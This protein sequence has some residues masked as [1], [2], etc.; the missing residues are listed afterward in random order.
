MKLDA[1]RHYWR[2]QAEAYPWISDELAVFKR[3]FLP[4][5]AFELDKALLLDGVVAVQA[6]ASECE[7]D[8]LLA[9]AQQSA[10]CH[11]KEQIAPILGIVGWVDL[12]AATVDARLDAYRDQP[13]MRGFRHLVQDE[14]NPSAFWARTDFNRG[15]S[16]LQKR[17]FVYDVLVKQAD[18]AAAV[19]FCARHDQAH[20]VLD[21]L[22]KPNFQAFDA[23]YQQMQALARMPHVSVKISGLLL[24]AGR[25]SAWERVKP[26]VESAL[27]LFGATRCMLGSDD[28]V[29][30]LTHSR[31]EVLTFWQSALIG[32]S[33]AE[34]SALTGETAARW[35]GIGRVGS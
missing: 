15:V 1:H 30:L 29:C 19:Q 22:G 14:A 26:Y 11:G 31:S 33:D 3:D 28:P 34:Q 13:L 7:N 4:E 6:R 9:L 32:L 25:G 8:F 23:W 18:L 2:Y 27:A 24:E 10:A 20:L 12:C 21:H 35:Y 16:A 17:G 5:H